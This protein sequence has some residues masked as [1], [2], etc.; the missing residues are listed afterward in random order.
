MW[1]IS[2]GGG[3]GIVE[4]GERWGLTNLCLKV[5]KV[6]FNLSKNTT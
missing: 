4:I 3:G 5:K 2:R 1:G 6:S